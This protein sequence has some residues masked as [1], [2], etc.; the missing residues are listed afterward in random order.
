MKLNL[1]KIKLNQLVL[2]VAAVLVIVWIIRRMRV[3]KL[4]GKE[5]EMSIDDLI[6]YVND[7]KDLAENPCYVAAKLSGRITSEQE[8]NLVTLS[9]ENDRK[10]VLTLLKS[11]Q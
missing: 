6:K 2:F 3:E 7:T 1:R 10:S 8:T 11:L 9:S 4:E 5:E